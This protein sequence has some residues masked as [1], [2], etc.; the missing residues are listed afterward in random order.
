M[1]E[2]LKTTRPGDHLPPIELKTFKD[3]ELCV[4]THLK[5]YIKI[6]VPFRNTNTNHFLLSFVQ[7]HKPVSVTTLSRWCVTVMKE[8]GINVN[9]FRSHS[10]WSASPSKC[11]ISGLSFKEIARSAG[12]SNEKTFAKFYD[13]PIQEDFPNSRIINYFFAYSLK[14]PFI[15]EDWKRIRREF[16]N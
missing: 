10:T 1:S 6:T 7:P 5:Q 13:K 12:W 2:T 3:S 16:T 9:I 14:S 4:V 15:R 8:S 11:K